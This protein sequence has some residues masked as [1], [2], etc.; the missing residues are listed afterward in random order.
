[1]PYT[2][3][4]GYSANW[5]HFVTVSRPACGE[6]WRN[7]QRRWM[8]HMSGY[9]R[10]IPKSNQV[11]A[12]RLLQCFTVVV[13]PLRVEKLAEVLAVDF[14]VSEG[15]PK[16]NEALRW[17]DQEQ[18]VLSACSSFD[19]RHRGRVRRFACGPVFA[20]LGQRIPDF[21]SPCHFEDGCLPLSYSP[22]AGTRNHGTGLSRCPTPIRSPHR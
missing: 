8:R 4:V 17:E 18:A 11:H 2:G 7:C 14:N 12:H 16:L 9:C 19:R 5:K 3:F 13:R 6:F 15:I 21:R 10:K 1:M 22:R 20:F